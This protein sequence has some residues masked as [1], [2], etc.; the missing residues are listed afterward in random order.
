MKYTKRLIF[1]IALSF[2]T[3][4]S[5]P[6]GTVDDPGP[7]GY[8]FENNANFYENNSYP[9]R[10]EYDYLFDRAVVRAG[11]V[12]ELKDRDR[13]FTVFLPDLPFLEEELKKQGVSAEQFLASPNLEVFVKS[14]II[15]GK[16]LELYDLWRSDGQT[17]TSMAGTSITVRTE[18]V[19]AEGEATNKIF[20]NDVEVF[21]YQFS[22]RAP[23][24]EPFGTTNGV[25]QFIEGLLV[26]P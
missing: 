8:G 3:A 15:E 21:T 16:W 17:F 7:L 26:K 13:E 11:L 22:P 14:H 10:K 23:R 19:I 6:T 9:D 25:L 4:C 12:D 18:T 1:I 5:Q 20:V 24:P 2:L